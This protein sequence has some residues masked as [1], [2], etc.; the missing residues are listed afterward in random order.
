MNLEVM[1]W[2]FLG[3]LLG[4]SCIKINAL[5]KVP[6][7]LQSFIVWDFELVFFT[8]IVPVMV[9]VSVLGKIFA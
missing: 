5:A 6:K 7:E 8:L 9:V 2:A 1:Y 4:I 3:I